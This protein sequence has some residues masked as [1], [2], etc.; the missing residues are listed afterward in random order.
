MART[1]KEKRAQFMDTLINKMFNNLDPT[2]ANSEMYKKELSVMTDE[3]FDKWVRNE[4]AHDEYNLYW[5]SIEFES[6]A[7]IENIKKAADA[8]HIPLY[9]EVAIPYLNG[10]PDN[11]IMSPQKVPV[12]FIHVKR[13]PQTIHH[14]NA[15]STSIDIRNGKTGQ[16]TGA[17]KNGRN[18]DVETYDLIAYG[19]KYSLSEFLNPRA[20]DEVKKN[21]MYAKIERDGVVYAKD[22]SSTP[23]DKA[24]INTLDIYY[25][26][27]GCN[28][29]II[30]GGKMIASPRN[31]DTK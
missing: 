4:F 9:E 17:D 15:G 21:Q 18:T 26:A 5:E 7:K 6:D 31:K 19:A 13:M 27:M 23:E 11:V 8:L 12:G 28:T 10:D 22:L 29:N 25:T 2:K 20:D 14:K 30:N 3:Q 24:A 16:V 1:I